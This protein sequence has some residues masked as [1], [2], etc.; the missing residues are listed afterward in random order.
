MHKNKYILSVITNMNYNELRYEQLPWTEKY[1]PRDPSDLILPKYLKKK[2]QMFVD[3]KNIP[4]IVLTGPSG[5]GKTSTIRCIARS[6]YGPYAKHAVLE[7]NASDDRGIKTIQDTIVNFCRTS[8]IFN[9]EDK[10]KYCTKKLII[11]DEADNMV[12]RSQ[13]QI[14]NTMEFYKD[15]VIFAFTCNSSS[16]INEAIQSK[17][18][19]LQYTRADKS[20]IVQKLNYIADKESI[21][22]D[23]GTTEKIA[24][25]CRGDMRSAIN[26]L[27][28]LCIKEKRLT[29]GIVDEY[30][31]LPQQ[32]TICK[33]FNSVIKNDL[34]KALNYIFELKNNGYTGSDIVMNMFHTIKS[35]MCNDIDEKYKIP[36][37]K[38]ICS[39]AYNISKSVDS[40]LQL[41]ACV[42]EMISNLSSIK[43][44]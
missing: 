34:K 25:I 42:T 43:K 6:L 7:L 1:R 16:N 31:D 27:H 44:N 33:I 28:M 35:D 5:I 40:I 23:A 37:C 39:S 26:I 22:Y 10:N 15:S 21:K 19:I 20:Q 18:C 9:E 29:T 36:I 38:A 11:L 30:C 4:N 3:N 32:I 14:N 41:T 24:D 12:D 8:L 2:V 17:C 13:P